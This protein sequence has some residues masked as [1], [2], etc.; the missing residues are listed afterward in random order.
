MRDTWSLDVLYTGFDD[1]RW[2]EDL[3]K[4]DDCVEKFLSF[5]A[6]LSDENEKE[7]IKEGLKL[8]EELE[9]LS[10]Q[11]MI[12]CELRGAAD[13]RDKDSM[14]YEGVLSQK[15]N[16]TRAAETKF[17]EYVAARKNLEQ[18][19]KE[20][21]FLTSYAYL[22]RNMAEDNR[23]L[24]SGDVE[25]AL[26]K[27][28]ISGGAA[29]SSLQGYLTSSVEA[30]L[31]GKKLTLSEVRNLAYSPSR[32]ERKAAYEAEL[33]CY[34]KIKDSVAYALNSI[35][36]QDISECELR[37]FASPLAKTLYYAR[38]KEETLNAL[39]EAMTE[40]M[41]QFWRYLRLKA[42]KLGYAD[43]LPWYELF[44]PLGKSTKRYTTEEARDCLITVFSSFSPDMAEMMKRAFAEDW[45][46][47]YPRNGKVG[48]A[49]CEALNSK[50]EFRVLTNFSGSFSDLVTLAHEL[51][52]GYHDFMVH[53]NEPLNMEYSMPVAETAS[54]FNENVITGYAIDHT[55]DEEEKLALIE[56]QLSDTA[57]IM[58]DIYSRFLFESEVV[59][60]RRESFLF[61][62]ELNEIMLDA[63]KKAYGNGLDENCLH[64]YMWV[65]KSHYYS[66]D[67][68]FYNYPYAFGGLFARGLYAKY[69]KE[70]S[71]FVENYKKMLKNTPVMS[72]ED[73]AKICGIDLTDKEFWMMSLHSY[74]AEI[75]EFEQLIKNA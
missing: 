36:M 22:L 12:F 10:A 25:E 26:A 69:K 64:P 24:L 51:G 27:M 4:L 9:G 52:H 30:D 53:D 49:F 35:K 41:P 71:A 46:D 65:C 32:E 11:M 16:R 72:V 42:E 38:M 31:G 60:R 14:S 8:L 33:A 56:S 54:T 61:A 68:G 28:D 63:Q 57:Q 3:K 5:A 34:D 29:W 45:I 37:G 1:K 74:D 67:L 7:T 17:A 13:T 6:K 62:D 20:D 2:S 18:D 21:A 44:A 40:Y 55:G 19:I 58:C 15:R 59:E 43:G 48:G 50:K 75:D 73:V 70:G 39:L 66:A 23:H 47:F